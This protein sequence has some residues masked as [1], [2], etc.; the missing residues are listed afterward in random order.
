MLRSDLQNVSNVIV[1]T[2]TIRSRQHERGLNACQ[3]LRFP[4]IHHGNRAHRVLWYQ[5]HQ[6]WT[7]DKW[8]QILFTDESRFSLHPD[9]RRMLIWRQ[10]GDEE[11]LRK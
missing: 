6:N 3:P 2:Q 5:Q 7:V 10:P 4:A 11:R 1:S 9:S 8:G